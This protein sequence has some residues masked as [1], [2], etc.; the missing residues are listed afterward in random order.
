MMNWLPKIMLLLL[1]FFVLPAHA[2]SLNKSNKHDSTLPIEVLA[3]QLE[4][5]QDE[6]KA[7][8]R[9]NVDALQGDMLLRAD[10]LIVYY[11][12]NNKNPDQPGI[13]SIDASG[14]V[15]VSSPT[16]TA[17]GNNGI[18]DVDKSKIVLVGDVILT[19]GE[20]VIKGEYLEMNLVTGESL[21]SRGPKNSA[22]KD[23]VRGLF[24][25]DRKKE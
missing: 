3:D 19:Q 8:F 13:S 21:V 20:N 18:Y 1:L 22:G 11:K 9:G 4:V 6:N 17:K 23:R 16:E 2:E 5:K 7:I 25:P 10:I 15:F 24:I 14:N 12:N